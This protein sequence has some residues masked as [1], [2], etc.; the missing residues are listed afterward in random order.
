[1][2]KLM[3]NCFY[4]ED[5]KDLPPTFLLEGLKESNEI[6]IFGTLDG[7]TFQQ[8]K[9]GNECDE[10]DAHL[11]LKIMKLILPSKI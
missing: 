1:M 3:V 8:Y 4:L 11:M 6:M 2:K 5:S 7:P 10:M 9:V